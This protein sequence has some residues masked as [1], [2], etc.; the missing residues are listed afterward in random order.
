VAKSKK[1]AIETIPHNDGWA[2]KVQGSSRVA[3]T[4]STK[5][6]AQAKGREMAM[7]RKVEHIVKKQ[8]GSIGERN[9][10]GNDPHPPKG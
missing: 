6:E 3:N 10:Y 5:K 7:K 8:D 2:N 1:P 4:A 9:S